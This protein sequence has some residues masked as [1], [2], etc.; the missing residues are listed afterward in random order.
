MES[1]PQRYA[2]NVLETTVDRG[3]TRANDFLKD[4]KL[5]AVQFDKA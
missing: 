2:K 3:V 4:R 1:S 5:L